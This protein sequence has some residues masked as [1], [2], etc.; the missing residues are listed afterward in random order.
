MPYGNS[1]TNTR[2]HKHTKE[3]VKIA[4]KQSISRPKDVVNDLFQHTGG[5]LGVKSVV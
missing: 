5:A 4:I 1:E 2:P 3:S